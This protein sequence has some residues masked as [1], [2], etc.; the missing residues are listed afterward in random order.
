MSFSIN[1]RIDCNPE[2][3]RLHVST[4]NSKSDYRYVRIDQG[5]AVIDV[6]VLL[7]QQSDNEFKTLSPLKNLKSR[8]KKAVQLP[9]FDEDLQETS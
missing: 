4:G 8:V 6:D 9:L 3:N 1:I 7:W 2:K 5:N